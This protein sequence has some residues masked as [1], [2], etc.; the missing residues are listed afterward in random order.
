M[1]GNR[2]RHANTVQVGSM[3]RWIVIAVFL[4]I[5]GLS[6]VYMSNQTQKTGTEIHKLE[7]D[8]RELRAR[9]DEAE[10]KI[11]MLSSHREL[12]RRLEEG[13]IKM[14]PITDDRIVRINVPRR[15]ADE[16]RPVANRGIEK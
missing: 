16:L 5:A 11:A 7:T 1:N 2:R 13:F 12:Q 9:N 14:T 4:G 8:L 6:Y 10:A 15:S 3:L